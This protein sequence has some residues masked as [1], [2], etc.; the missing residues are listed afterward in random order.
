MSHE[1]QKGQRNLGIRK[2]NIGFQKPTIINS[3]PITKSKKPHHVNL[4]Q[5]KKTLSGA[6]F[7]GENYELKNPENDNIN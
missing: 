6:G 7:E 2:L 3:N 4:F 1:P 5:T